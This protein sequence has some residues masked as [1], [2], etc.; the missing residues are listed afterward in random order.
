S[1]V[2]GS[3]FG[4][5]VGV[6]SV[7]SFDKA[8]KVRIFESQIIIENTQGLYIKSLQAFSTDGRLLKTYSVNSDQNAYIYHSLPKGAALLRV[9]GENG[10]TATY[11]TII[12]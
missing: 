10:K 4:T 1:A 5:N 2:A 3:P 8:V 11:K 6:E 9:L 12:L 7:Q